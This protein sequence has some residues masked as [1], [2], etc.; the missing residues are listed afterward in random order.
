MTVS[1]RHQLLAKLCAAPDLFCALMASFRSNDRVLLER[2]LA[3]S[4]SRVIHNT[5]ARIVPRDAALFLR[6]AVD[7]W[8]GGD[9]WQ[10]PVAHCGRV[11]KC[12]LAGLSKDRLLAGEGEGTLSMYI[13]LTDERVGECRLWGLSKYRL[14]AGERVGKDRLLAGAREGVPS[15]YVFTLLSA[16]LWEGQGTCD[17]PLMS[18]A[19]PDGVAL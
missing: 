15:K 7:R 17:Y 12:W 5:V 3:T 9:G 18:L 1:C 2:C 4:S 10:V 11:C 14:L 19:W 16:K 6:A 8:G 13:L